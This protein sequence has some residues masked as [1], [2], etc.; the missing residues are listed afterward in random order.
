MKD[1][2]KTLAYALMYKYIGL[3]T[4]LIGFICLVTDYNWQGLILVLVALV[5]MLLS[6][7]F[8]IK[9]IVTVLKVKK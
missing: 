1:N 2:I 5:S 7:F 6:A 4:Y 3:V 8:E 9:F